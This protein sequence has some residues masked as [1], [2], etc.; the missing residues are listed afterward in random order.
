MLEPDKLPRSDAPTASAVQRAAAMLRSPLAV[1]S[2]LRACLI[3]AAAL[4]G[5]SDLAELLWHRPRG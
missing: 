1:E 5:P 3:S 4:A 2:R